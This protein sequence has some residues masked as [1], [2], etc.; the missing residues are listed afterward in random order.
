MGARHTSRRRQTLIF[1]APTSYRSG[2]VVFRVCLPTRGRA[3]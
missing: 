1:A 2:P 3:E